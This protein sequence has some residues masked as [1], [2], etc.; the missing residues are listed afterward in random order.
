M[1]IAILGTGF[2]KEHAKLFCKEKLVDKIIVWGRNPEKLKE[3][4]KELGV[5]TTTN[6]DDI[7]RDPTIELVDVCLPTKLH[8]EYAI[9]ALRAGKHVF[10]EMP[11]ADTVEN[12][13]K[14]QETAKE[15][16]RRVFVDLF[17]Q[18]EYPYQ[19]LNQI[20]E[21]KRYGECKDFYIRRQT[22]HWWGNLDLENISINLM[23]HDIDFVLQLLGKPDSIN[24]EG[25]NVRPEC[26]VVTALMSFKNVAATIHADSSIPGTGP[27]S[28]GFEATF[29][30]AFIRYFE[31]GYQDGRTET[32]LEIFTEEKHEE[33]KLVPQNCYELVCHNVVESILENKTSRL[34]IEHALLTLETIAA[35]EK[36]IKGKK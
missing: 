21:E 33:V 23:H 7:M 35:I 12:G 29:E 14:I 9:K 32:R 27:F 4:E 13:R 25:R 36:I 24:V 28:V 8:A 30:K 22:P 6:L 34:D 18:Y 5:Q 31:D 1:K 10:V 2:G 26:S 17:L 15:C 11:L 16:K 20:K 3:I 19:L